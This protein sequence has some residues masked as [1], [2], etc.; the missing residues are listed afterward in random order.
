MVSRSLE[1]HNL[2]HIPVPNFQPFHHHHLDLENN[3][4]TLLSKVAQQIHSAVAQVTF[5]S[6][7]EVSETLW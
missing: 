7:W 4:Q 1:K 2:M 6:Q 3:G 5:L